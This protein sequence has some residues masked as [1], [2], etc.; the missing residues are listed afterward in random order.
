MPG[1]DSHGQIDLTLRIN[2]VKYAVPALGSVASLVLLI[3]LLADS[4]NYRSLPFVSTHL[5]DHNIIH[6]LDHSYVTMDSTVHPFHRFES[7]EFFTPAVDVENKGFVKNKKGEHLKFAGMLP[8]QESTTACKIFDT[9]NATTAV[10][11]FISSLSDVGYNIQASKKDI[12]TKALQSK[13]LIPR[14]NKRAHNQHMA[15][16]VCDFETYMGNWIVFNENSSFSLTSGHSVYVFAVCI[17]IIL[18][19]SYTMH[20]KNAYKSSES[21]LREEKYFMDFLKSKNF[22]YAVLVLV[23]ITYFLVMRNYGAEMPRNNEIIRPNGSFA[24][25]LLAIIYS[26]AFLRHSRLDQTRFKGSFF[27]S[28]EEEIAT[29]DLNEKPNQKPSPDEV[30]RGIL[31]TPGGENSHLELNLSGFSKNKVQTNAYMQAGKHGRGE[32]KDGKFQLFNESTPSLNVSNYEQVHIHYSHFQMTQ[33]WVLPLLLLSIYIYDKNFDIDIHVTLVFVLSMI[34]C[35]LDIF[36]RRMLEMNSILRELSSNA[37]PWL[38]ETVLAVVQLLSGLVQ[39]S[40]AVYLLYF[41][42]VNHRKRDYFDIEGPNM[43]AILVV[44]FVFSLFYKLTRAVFNVLNATRVMPFSK[45]VSNKYEFF[46]QWLHYEY[47]TMFLLTI[48]SA[49]VLFDLMRIKN[50]AFDE[51]WNKDSCERDDNISN[52]LCKIFFKHMQSFDF[53]SAAY[54]HV[55]A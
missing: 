38:I 1:S 11:N 13:N 54:A 35:I 15:K 16:D 49:I 2:W 36:S 44:Y 3:V 34:Y 31:V 27:G 47:V 24:Y 14:S 46:T 20:I 37:M 25:G 29:A 52:T 23:L 26:W 8:W 10:N 51:W 4:S 40:I 55:A 41:L 18:F 9:S 50:K 17:W 5:V 19:M 48:L 42:D 45:E 28:I 21:R 53:N 33:L 22:D 7:N 12:I 39:L 43:F 32:L 30:P 6:P